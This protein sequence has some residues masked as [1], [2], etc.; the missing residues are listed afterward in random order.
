MWNNNVHITGNLTKDVEL[1]K[2]S[3]GKDTCTFVVAVNTNKQNEPSFITCSAWNQTAIYIAQYGKKGSRI[4]IEG[5]LRSFKYTVNDETRSALE[6]VATNTYIH[7]YKN[8]H[9]EQEIE[10]EED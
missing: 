3:N 8:T 9:E 5:N 6:V 4:S 2:T 10:E 7:T 1:R